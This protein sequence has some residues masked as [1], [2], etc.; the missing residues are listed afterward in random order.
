MNLIHDIPPKTKNGNY[1]MIVENPCGVSE[2]Y[3][4]NKE[5]GIIGLDRHLEA[6][7]PFPFEYGFIP[8][9]W[10]KADGDP[11]DVMA[12]LPN[13]TFVSCLLTI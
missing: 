6:P 9:T 7:M 11:V 1:H 2:K 12:L 13:P 8:G 10:N 3:E 4:V 5:F